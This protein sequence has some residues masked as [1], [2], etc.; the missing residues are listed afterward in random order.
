MDFLAILFR[1]FCFLARKDLVLFG[2]QLFQ[3]HVVHTKL[4]VF[5]FY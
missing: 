5:V 4:V 1:P 3:K 2:F